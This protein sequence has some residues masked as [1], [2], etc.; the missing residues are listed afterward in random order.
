MAYEATSPAYVKGII[1]GLI[2]AALGAFAWAAVIILFKSTYLI[3]SVGIGV[4]V[5]FLMKKAMGRVDRMRVR[6]RRRARPRVDIRR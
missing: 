3:L 6:D 4:M 2:G 1:V 5:A